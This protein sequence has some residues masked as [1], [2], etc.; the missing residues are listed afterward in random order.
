MR[1]FH[2]TNP[3]TG[4]PLPDAWP[5]ATDADVDRACAAAAR[6]F[7]PYAA[8]DGATRS[9]FLHRIADALEADREAIVSVA[10]AESGLPEGRLTGEL[11]RTT[12]QLRMF[13][14]LVADDDWR[15]VRVEVADPDR[16]PAPKPEV[17]SMKRALGP[18]V[19]FGASNFPLAF[20]TAG[21]DTASA[22][23]AGC[24]V[25]VKAHP[26]HPGTADRVARAVQAAARDTGLPDG[27]FTVLFDD[28]H[29]VGT[30]LVRDP[31]VRAVGFTGSRAGGDALVRIAA[32]RPVPIP[33]YA[34]MGSI[35]PV[36]VLPGAAAARTEA[37]AEGLHGSFTLGVGQF[38]TNPGVAFVP[39]GAVGDAVRTALA[40]RTAA[41]PA[42]TML[43][44]RVC[45]AYGQGVDA[46][47]A[48]GGR[49]IASGAAAD[50]A[51]TPGVAHAFEVELDAIR[52]APALL[53]EV[54]GPTTLLVRY[55]DA[56]ELAPFAASIEGQLTATVHGEADELGGHDALF[57]AL[58]DRVGRVI[59]NQWPTGVEV[60]PAMVHGGPYPATSDGR[61]TSVGTHAIDRFTRLVAY[62]NVPQELLP[63][64]LRDA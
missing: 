64:P 26:G 25:I 12:G 32:E 33:V 20:S 39:S 6:A 3:A 28:G 40:A 56:A 24:P 2:A 49:E 45:E 62:Q 55:D 22:L 46:L 52:E 38:C 61:S 43:N 16:A 50:D 7:A 58:A 9:A 15:D 42:G 59:V 37:I 29:E 63:A 47:R 31:R 17:R 21:G 57:S 14:E 36:F 44:A 53:H 19:V 60:G 23:A 11:G 30:A 13:A 5:V 10:G 51:A 4:A 8:S 1:T 18:V 54:F 27:V 35:N 48:A 41:T 34:E